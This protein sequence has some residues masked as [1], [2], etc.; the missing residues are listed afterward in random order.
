MPEHS[1]TD[2]AAFRA[3]FPY[4][5]EREVEFSDIDSLQHVNNVRYAV[6]AETLRVTY[7]ADVYGTRIDGRTGVIIA[8]H[9]MHYEAQLSYRERVVVGCRVARWGTKSFDLETEIWSP[10]TG[11]RV[12]RSTAVLVAYD[13]EAHASI[14]IPEHWRTA[15]PAP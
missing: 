14:P 8:R 9:D 13:Y 15:T 11:R 4:H 12:F 3:A 5:R 2:I 7:F 6:W 10:A 1:A